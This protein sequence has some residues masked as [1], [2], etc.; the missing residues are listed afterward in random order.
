MLRGKSLEQLSTPVHL[1]NQKSQEKKSKKIKKG[2]NFL[3]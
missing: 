2:T 1:K 3:E